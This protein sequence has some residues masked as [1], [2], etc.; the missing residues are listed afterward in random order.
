MRHPGTLDQPSQHVLVP[1][2][3][4]EVLTIPQAAKFAGMA[5]ATLRRLCARHDLGRRIGGEWKVSRVAL[6]MYLEADA[7]ALHAYLEGDRTSPLVRGYFAREG[8]T[9]EPLPKAG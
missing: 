4:R 8:L 6:R 1:W 5:E 2:N 3:V 9:C 7:R